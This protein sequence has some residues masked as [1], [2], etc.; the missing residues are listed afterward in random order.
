MKTLLIIL[1]NLLALTFIYG[2]PVTDTYIEQRLKEINDI[3]EDVWL[4]LDDAA[5]EKLKS[6]TF[7]EV[8]MY[9]DSNLVRVQKMNY[10]VNAENQALKARVEE[11]NRIHNEIVMPALLKATTLEEKLEIVRKYP[12]HF[13]YEERQMAGVTIPKDTLGRQ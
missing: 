3:S 11:H 2:Q 7:E 9:F 8:K 5:K 4:E 13:G 12:T 10:Q 6:Y 1:F